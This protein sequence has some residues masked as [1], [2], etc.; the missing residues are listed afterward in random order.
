MTKEEIAAKRAELDQA[1]KALVA[2]PDDPA[3]K[4]KAAEALVKADPEGTTK[5]VEPTRDERRAAAVTVASE[6][7]VGTLIG[8]LRAV[9]KKLERFEP[10]EHETPTGIVERDAEGKV[11]RLGFIK[12]KRKPVAE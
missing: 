10:E 11:T 1:E 3:A 6:E 2:N 7:S 8:L 12:L 9:D 4:K 5:I